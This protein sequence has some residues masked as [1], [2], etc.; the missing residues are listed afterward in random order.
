[1]PCSHGNRTPR[2]LYEKAVECRDG[3]FTIFGRTAE[4]ILKALEFWDNIPNGGDYYCM[5]HNVRYHNLDHCYKCRN[6][7]QE[8]M[9]MTREEAKEKVL[10]WTSL[11]DAL[12]TLGLL[13]FEEAPERGNKTIYQC[14]ITESNLKAL[15]KAGYT[16]VRLSPTD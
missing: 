10:S 2:E 12:E 5:K 7:K 14:G 6:E 16:I 1:M 11:V 15:E 9:K 13:K 3:I 4:E 8:Q